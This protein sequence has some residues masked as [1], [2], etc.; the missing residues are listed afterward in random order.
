MKPMEAKIKLTAELQKVDGKASH[1]YVMEII[2]E[3]NCV[4]LTF[5]AGELGWLNTQVAK[6]SMLDSMEVSIV[7]D[8]TVDPR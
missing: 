3:R 8:Q 4:R 2:Q 6:D 1:I 5:S 7:D